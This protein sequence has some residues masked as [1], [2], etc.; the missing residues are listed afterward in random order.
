MLANN[1]SVSTRH[2]PGTA[3]RLTYSVSCRPCRS[4]RFHDKRRVDSFMS[5][6]EACKKV[7]SKSFQAHTVR[8]VRSSQHVWSLCRL[9]SGCKIS[10]SSFSLV[11]RRWQRVRVAHTAHLIPFLH[12]HVLLLFVPVFLWSTQ[13]AI[14]ELCYLKCYF[15]HATS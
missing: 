10:T 1:T 15:R 2:R 11:S 13:M 6:R 3:L 5:Q 4:N 9:F 7:L 8:S 14:V 12:A